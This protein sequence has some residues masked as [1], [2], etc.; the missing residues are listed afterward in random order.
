GTAGLRI[1]GPSHNSD[2]LGE[3]VDE[4]AGLAWRWSAA[5]PP[6]V[7]RVTREDACV[8]AVATAI[9]PDESDLRVLAGEALDGK[10][11]G[12]RAIHYRSAQAAGQE[13]DRIWTWIAV[14]CVGL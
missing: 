9:P 2:R 5:G 7:Y 6:G 14:A 13:Q 3:L 12:G 8:L 10:L 1:R 4:P 11:A